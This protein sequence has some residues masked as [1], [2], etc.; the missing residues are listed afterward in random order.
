[1]VEGLGHGTTTQRNT[2][3]SVTGLVGLTASV[4]KYY[5]LGGQP[6]AMAKDGV[7]AWLHTDHLGSA[8]LATNASG[9]K[10]ALLAVGQLSGSGY[11]C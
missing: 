11:I 7:V 4:T 2:P 3:T 5:M 6:V 1:M 9:L 10:V 8:S